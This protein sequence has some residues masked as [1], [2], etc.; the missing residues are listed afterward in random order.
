M[1]IK[2]PTDQSFS[3]DATQPS[4][5]VNPGAGKDIDATAENSNA[6]LIKAREYN[7]QNE[8]ARERYLNASITAG[9]P[10]TSLTNKNEICR[11]EFNYSSETRLEVRK[12]KA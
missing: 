8:L 10:A 5:S 9:R 6:D 2:E 4:K 3:L 1:N 7:K 12:L 11:E